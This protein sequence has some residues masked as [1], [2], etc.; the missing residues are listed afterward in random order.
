MTDCDTP[1]ARGQGIPAAELLEAILVVC[2]IEQTIGRLDMEGGPMRGPD[3]LASWFRDQR[4]WALRRV[5]E[6]QR[7]EILAARDPEALG[8]AEAIVDMI[9]EDRR[10]AFASAIRGALADGEEP[11]TRPGGALEQTACAAAPS[12]DTALL[13]AMEDVC[14]EAMH[15]TMA[16][17]QREAL[18]SRHGDVIWD[19]AWA[20]TCSGAWGQE[21]Y[22][23][24]LRDL[25]EARGE[26]EEADDE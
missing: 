2:D 16:R 22:A 7:L 11:D 14:R 12:R 4:R 10:P 25:R 3:S 15:P 5:A 26:A 18:H 20:L 6:Y 23:R 21:R 1:G 8:T 13:D 19:H 9:E 17:T 24:Y